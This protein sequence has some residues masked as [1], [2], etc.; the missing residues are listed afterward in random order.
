MKQKQFH[1]NELEVQN[2]VLLHKLKVQ[3]IC[4][5]EEL[6][7]RPPIIVTLE[8]ESKPVEMK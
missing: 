1:V 8:I 2:L 4:V 5:Q 6:P 7:I 3:N